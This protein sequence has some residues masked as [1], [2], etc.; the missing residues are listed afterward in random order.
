M[1]LLIGIPAYNEEKLI[2]RVIESLPHRLTG[3]STIDIVV[4][5]DG[6]SDRTG[7]IAR[8]KKAMVLTHLLNRG[9]GGSLK[10][11]IEYAKQGS[12]DIAVTFD[13]DGQHSAG[14]IG[15]II[16]PIIKKNKDIVIGT[17]WKNYGSAPISRRVINF[18]ANLFTFLLY[19]VYTTDSQS[20]FRSLNKKAINSIQLH[21]DGME[22]SSE[23]FKEI[24]RNKLHFTE[25][26]IHAIYT[27]YSKS[28]GQRLTNAPNIF[29]QLFVRLLR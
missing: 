2:G 27:T 26:P 12:Y 22:V 3:I 15:K 1:K 10:T 20:G 29:I 16:L 13:A 14:D 23:F 9:L 4:V 18:L 24:Y 21:T 28:K 5:D 7:Q 25:V 11:I 8:E 19:G 6:S 17:R